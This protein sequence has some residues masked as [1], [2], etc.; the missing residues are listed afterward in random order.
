[1]IQLPVTKTGNSDYDITLD[2]V[3]YTIQYRYNT[4]DER[5]YMNILKGSVELI[6]GMVLIEGLIINWPYANSEA[7]RGAFAVVQFSDDSDF[8]TLGNTGI[9]QT[10]S[11]I[12]Y[13]EDEITR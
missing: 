9:S 4:R 8:A 5:I 3:T 2:G 10:F 7:P 11:L 12:Y 1:M 13:T 6:M